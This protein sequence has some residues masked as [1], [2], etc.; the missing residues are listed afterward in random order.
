[1]KKKLLVFLL[2]AALL[3]S[4]FVITGS[5]RELDSLAQIAA[6]SRIEPIGVSSANAYTELVDVKAKDLPKSYS[7]KD[8]GYT[9][10]VRQQDTNTCWAY[11]SLATFETLLLKSGETVEHFSPQHM[12]IWGTTENSGLGWQREDLNFDGGYSYIA[13][14]YL[15]SWNGPLLESELP[16]GSDRDAYDN[17][18]S[19]YSP[20]YG[21]TK[22]KYVDRKTP[23]ETIKS[24][25]MDYGAVLA[26]YNADTD[27]F[28]NSE[29]DSFYCSDET[30]PT[31]ALQGHAVSIVGWDDNYPKEKFST[32]NSGDTPNENGAWLF[33]NSWGDVNANG[34]YFW[35]SYED[36]WLFHEIFGPSFTIAD[37]INLDGSHKIYQNEI[38]GATAQFSFI[39]DEYRTP[40][41]AIT[42]INVFD[43]GSEFSMLDKVVFE[44]TSFGADFT[45]Y[46]IPVYGDKPTRKTSTWTK[47]YT[48]TVD[49][50]GYISVDINDFEVPEGK[51]A[52]GICVD[53]TNTYNENKN[54]AGYK[55]IPNS[56]GVCEWL[57]YGGEYYFINQGEF[58]ESFIMYNEFGQSEFYDLMDYYGEYLDDTMGA[59]FVIKAILSNPDFVP[60]TSAPT[61]TSPTETHSTSPTETHSTT[62]TETTINNATTASTENSEPSE[63]ATTT[64]PNQGKTYIIGDTS[65]NG[66][67]GIKDATLIRKHLARIIEFDKVTLTIADVDGS[68]RCTIKDATLIQKYIALIEVPSNVG[69]TIVLYDN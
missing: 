51:G 30:I 16:V 46:Y 25:I 12:N 19:R 6:I 4:S 59:T 28:M 47:L 42:Y 63:T 21:V 3:L 37:Y 18:N 14:G 38:Y 17:A 65:H 43:F 57:G 15:S 13:M 7:S 40:A 52:I 54:N 9:T 69:K 5:A 60:D 49:Y 11:S 36:A 44:S 39:T 27:R 32:S 23:V 45:V 61:S 8:L 53:N 58:G 24:Y 34:G 48:G 62:P 41:N 64:A 20:D 2:I 68:E 66:T 26:N 55:Y 56:L 10:P 50:T 35:I 1:M 67:I 31:N 29:T 33:K 22:I